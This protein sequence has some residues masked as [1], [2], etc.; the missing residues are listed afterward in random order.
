MTDPQQKMQEQMAFM[1]AELNQLS[2]EIFAQQKEIA[3]LK[4]ALEF[5]KA[6]LNSAQSDSGI[7]T[8]AED[9]PPP[10]Y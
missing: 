8:P 9:R 6:K 10:H 1:Q 7:L 5:V 3:A 2:D 4:T